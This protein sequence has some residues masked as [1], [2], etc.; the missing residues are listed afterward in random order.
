[1]WPVLPQDLNPFLIPIVI[2]IIARSF[3][4]FWIRKKSAEIKKTALASS[5]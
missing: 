4:Q 2:A 1:L 5:L 3:A